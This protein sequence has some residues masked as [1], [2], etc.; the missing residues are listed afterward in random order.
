MMRRLLTTLLAGVVACAGCLYSPEDARAQGWK[1]NRPVQFIVPWGAGGGSDRIA[2][3]VAIL[4]EKELGQPVTVVNRAGGSGAVGHAAGATAAPDGHTI[5]NLNIDIT[6]LHWTG[7]TPI[8]Y[9]D[10]TPVAVLNMDP[11][12][13]MV[14]ANSEWKSVRQVL[15]YA[16]ANPGKLRA[17][18]SPAASTWHLAYIGLL[19][20]ARIP[21]DAMPFIPSQ[22]AAS[23]LQEL[24]SG[25][26]HMVTSSLV[27]GGPLMDAGKVRPLANMA[28]ERDPAFGNVPTL[29]E[30]GYNWTIGAWRSVALPKSTPA[31]IVAAYDK[32]L[33]SVVKNKEFVEFMNKNGFKIMYKPAAEYAGW[34]AKQDELMG[35]VMKEAGLAKK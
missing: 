7:V 23:A 28:D 15:D 4:L 29:K 1:P 8:T 11:A 22:G 18:G 32:A 25:G 14:A 16:K 3:M 26:V 5:T 30:L 20:T 33:A 19:K 21:L 31:E 6:F 12:G 24:T 17:S 9:R 13:V 34:I 10:F 27:E 35:G 2:R